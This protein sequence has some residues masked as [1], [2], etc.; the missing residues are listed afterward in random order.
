MLSKL[1]IQRYS[2]LFKKRE[3]DQITSEEISE[4]RKYEILL[5]YEVFWNGRKAYLQLARDFMNSTINPNQF[6]LNFFDLRRYHM[7]LS[8][9]VGRYLFEKQIF[10]QPTFKLEGFLTL[11]DELFYILDLYEEDVQDFK[12][13]NTLVSTKGLKYYVKNT[14]IPELE[15][16]IQ[17]EENF[18]NQDDSTDQI[19]KLKSCSQILKLIVMETTTLRNYQD[20]QVL[21]S[22]M[23]LLTSFSLIGYL[24]LKPSILN[25]ILNYFN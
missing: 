10:I 12:L 25:F 16:Y 24:L 18:L 11:I 13:T 15:N 22:T 1:N 3:S 17:K 14:F 9:N 6:T 5:E 4:L 20:N 23:F 2:Q 21:R 7:T 8:E 19:L